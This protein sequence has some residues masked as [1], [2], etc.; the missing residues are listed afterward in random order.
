MNHWFQLNYSLSGIFLATIFKTAGLPVLCLIIALSLVFATREP[1]LLSVSVPVLMPIVLVLAGTALGWRFG[2]SNAVLALIVLLLSYF[3]LGRVGLASDQQTF[4]QIIYAGVSILLPANLLIFALFEERGLLNP[5]G[6]L[7]LA[8]ILGQALG[9][10][11]IAE[12]GDS[13]AHKSAAALFH[14]RF[15]PFGS[16]RWTSLPELSLSVHIL[17]FLILSVRLGLTRSPIGGG[18]LGATVAGALAFLNVS[19]SSSVQIFLIT[20]M[21]ILTTSI[22][23]VVYRMAFIDELTG[24]PGRRA[25]M[26]DMRKLGPNYVIAMCDIDHFKQFNDTYGHNI[27]DQVL[28]MVAGQLSRVGGGGKAYRY[29]GEEFSILLPGKN[30][31]TAKP[32]LEEIRTGVAQSSFHIRAKD[33][34]KSKPKRKA[35]KS[36]ARKVF[37][38]I[39]IGF[40]DTQKNNQPA[41]EILKQADAALYRAKKAGRNCVSA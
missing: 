38:T 29:G 19:E 37:V 17:A 30:K 8:L 25:L 23:Q 7:R 10:Y 4:Q 26:M 20:A 32:F 39:S 5:W 24:I 21:A 27:G 2:Q 14:Y 40:A 6:L 12:Y 22:L 1:L 34:P 41:T 28:R 13:S 11:W 16:D 33:R 9:L 3:A 31:R 36:G 18:F 35:K 15:L